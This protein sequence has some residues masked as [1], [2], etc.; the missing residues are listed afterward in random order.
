MFEPVRRERAVGW[1]GDRGVY[2]RSFLSVLHKKPRGIKNNT[3]N[4]AHTV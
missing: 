4:D 3:D 1:R 2:A